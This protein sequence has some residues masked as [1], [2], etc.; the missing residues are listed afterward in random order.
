MGV[1]VQGG[2]LSVVVTPAERS[3]RKGLCEPQEAGGEVIG[4]DGSL[5]A[6][7]LSRESRV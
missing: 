6:G 2:T 4:E 7:P 5:R 1:R 3:L